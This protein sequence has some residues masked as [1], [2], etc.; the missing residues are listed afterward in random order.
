MRRR[1]AAVAGALLGLVAT[2][3]A[4]SGAAEIKVL[5]AGAFKQVLVAA[6]PAFEQRTGHTV[7]LDNATVG[8]LIQ[9]I[10]GGEAFDVAVL[11]PAAI[12]ALTAKGKIA[13]GT[14]KALA[15]VGVGVVVKAGAPKPD[16]ATVDAFKRALLDAKSVAYIDPAAGGSSGIYIA[17]LLKQLGVAD[18]VNA[19]AKLIQGGAVADHIAAGEAELGLHQIS[20]ILPVAG[21]TLVGPLPAA[22]QNYTVYAAGISSAA[23]DRAA[24]EALIDQ[25]AG[26]AGAAVIT[27][28]GM[29]PAS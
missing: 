29:E 28:K 4:P 14:R 24:A 12:D 20:E 23:R 9:R 27:A 6:L 13:A 5:T 1:L 11:S 25:L 26:P 21:V 2:T 17:K 19:K 3:A 15:K 7:T 8:V 18:A 22:L 16:I 10:E